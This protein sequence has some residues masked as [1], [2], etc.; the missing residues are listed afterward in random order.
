MALRNTTWWAGK[1]CKPK[2][3]GGLGRSLH[4]MNKALL[5]K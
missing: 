4:S 1:R 2:D 3:E 5:F